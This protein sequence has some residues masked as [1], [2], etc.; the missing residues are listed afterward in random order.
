MVKE[1]LKKEKTVGQLA[2]SPT[3]SGPRSILAQLREKFQ[4]FSVGGNITI[5]ISPQENGTLMDKTPPEEA[6]HT[7]SL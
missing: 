3:G 6:R 2:F 4:A 5:F 1:M 7:T